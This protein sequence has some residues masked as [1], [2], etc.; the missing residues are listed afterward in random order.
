MI[1]TTSNKTLLFRQDEAKVFG[2]NGALVLNQIRYWTD[3]KRAKNFKEDRLWVYNSLQ[4]WKAEFVSISERTLR[5][6]FHQLETLGVLIAKKFNA[7]RRDQ[8]KWH[9]INFEKLNEILQNVDR[10][11]SQ[12]RRMPEPNLSLKTKSKNELKETAATPQ[13]SRV[14]AESKQENG[15][16]LDVAKLATCRSGQSGHTSKVQEITQKITSLSSSSLKKENPQDPTREMISIWHQK[17]EENTIAFSLTYWRRRSLQK[18]LKQS[19]QNDLTA[20]AEYCDLIAHNTFL[21]GGGPNGWKIFLDWALR[22]QNIE[23]VQE[24]KYTGQKDVPKPPPVFS[25]DTLQGSEVWKTMASLL[26]ERL[27]THT[28][29]AWFTEACLKDETSEYPILSLGTSF[30]ASYVQQRYNAVIEAAAKEAMPYTKSLRL[31]A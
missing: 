9:T 16:N 7:W 20:W 29:Y 28:F 4:D 2:M 6:V 13:I 11:P 8:R 27:G 14:S 18:T 3:P 26:A 17:I 1:N 30:R 5:R 12:R 21:M 25:K 23:K 31:T 22:P 19:F 10:K 15:G 24:K